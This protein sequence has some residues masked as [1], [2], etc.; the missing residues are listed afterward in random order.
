M[1]DKIAVKE[2]VEN[3]RDSLG[4]MISI[5]EEIQA[6]CG[7]LPEDA[8]REVAAATGRSLT[9]IYGVATF[10]KAFSLKPRGKHLIAVCI[11]TACH[12][13][14]AQRIVEEFS[15]Q[16]GIKTGETTPDKVFTL[17]TVNCLGACA[18]G[19]TV[20]VDS[21]YFRHVTTA[22]VPHI[23]EQARRGFDRGDLSTDQRIFALEARC[24]RCRHSLMDA[25]HPVDGHPSICLNVSTGDTRGWLRL[26]SLYGSHNIECQREIAMGTETPL[27]CPHCNQELPTDAHCAECGSSMAAMD[28][29]SNARVY[30][31]I[32]RGCPGHRLD[33]GCFCKPSVEQ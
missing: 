7:Y 21:R 26:S 29:Q 13:R 11:G 31:C 20:V 3:R 14:G 23:L 28:L 15:K 30:V 16:L 6:R 1:D 17:E 2:I 33:L 27:Y 19:P 18:L 32:R 5:L 4:G 12:V 9:D 22:K 8:V 24:I 10:Y 25:T